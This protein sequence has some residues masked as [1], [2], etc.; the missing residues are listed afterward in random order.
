MIEVER[1]KIVEETI[2]R[3]PGSLLRCCRMRFIPK[4]SE[5]MKISGNHGDHS[6]PLLTDIRLVF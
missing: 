1:F 3:L 4:Q 6:S 2:I 5:N